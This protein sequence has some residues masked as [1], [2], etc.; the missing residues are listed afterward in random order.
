MDKTTMQPVPDTWLYL[1]RRDKDDVFNFNTQNY[2]IIEAKRSDAQGKA[3]FTFNFEEKYTYDFYAV[4]ENG[5]YD[6]GNNRADIPYKQKDG[7]VFISLQP[8]GYI[9]FRI[10]DIE[11]LNPQEKVSISS[12]IRGFSYIKGH[13]IDTLI[14][15]SAVSGNTKNEIV[16]WVYE[17]QYYEGDKYGLEVY[18]PAHDTTLVTIEY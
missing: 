1:L 12:Y 9:S 13:N 2:E 7:E 11:P 5:Y 10:K 15:C 3:E 4:N 17:D 8:I 18:V 14:C 16:W 6:D